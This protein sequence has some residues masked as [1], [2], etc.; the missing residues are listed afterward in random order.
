MTCSLPSCKNPCIRTIESEHE[1]HQCHEV[2]CQKK[3]TI[4]GCS[5]SCG[6]KD[7]FHDL[8]AGAEHL[9]GNEHARAESCE[10]PGICEIFTE[11]VRQNRVFQGQRGSFE[12]EHVSEQNG[13]RKGCCIP[14][15][16]FQRSHQGPHVH[17]KN[18]NVVH[19]CDTRCQAC[20]YFCR[21]PLDHHGLHD[22]VHGNMRNVRFISEEEDNDI[23]DRKYKWGEKGEAEMCHIYCRKQGRGHIHLVPCP[24]MCT[25]NLYDGSRHETV[26]YGPDVD[27]SKDGMTHDTYWKYVRFVDPCTQEERQ[28][29]NRCSHRHSSIVPH[30]VIFVIDKL[31]SM[32]TSDITPTMV[33]F[34][35]HN[36]RLGYVYEAILRF[37]ITSQIP[38]S[39]D[40]ISVILFN[41][42]ATV[43]VEIQD[44]EDGVVDRLLPHQSHGGTTFSSGLGSAEQ[45]MVKA[46][47]DLRV[48]MKV[49]VVIFL[50]DGGNK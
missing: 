43:A 48:H 39:D 5:R 15:P 25:N 19:Y 17:T 24:K 42:S 21:L 12:Y 23:Q 35:R 40:S 20:G 4:K 16:R 27:V 3:C 32:G 11:L 30:H 31:G 18:E 6:V 44:M 47:R 14:I 45:L 49:P 8:V 46:T 33:R 26:K 7:H 50:S 13:L 1:K 28:E 37:I 29:F 34:A 38:V 10:M 2:Y 36:S 41:K 22:T 9:C